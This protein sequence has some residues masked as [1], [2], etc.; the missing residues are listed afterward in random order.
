[1]SNANTNTYIPPP[2]TQGHNPYPPSPQHQ[3]PAAR[4]PNMP[5]YAPSGPQSELPSPTTNQINIS[6]PLDLK[7][8]GPQPILPPVR[9]AHPPPRPSLPSRSAS[10]RR[11]PSQNAQRQESSAGSVNHTLNSQEVTTASSVNG[12]NQ[13]Q[14]NQQSHQ[15]GN[16]ASDQYQP[17][18]PYSNQTSPQNSPSIRTQPNSP[19]NDNHPGTSPTS[20]YFDNKSSTQSDNASLLTVASSSGLQRSNSKINYSSPLLRHQSRSGPPSPSTPHQPLKRQTS[21]L[22]NGSKDAPYLSN[23]K[24]YHSHLETLNQTWEPPGPISVASSSASPPSS[25]SHHPLAKL[26]SASNLRAL[27]TAAATVT[28][29]G[30]EGPTVTSVPLSPMK[31]QE[32]SAA[33]IASPGDGSGLQGAIASTDGAQHA[34]EPKD[35]TVHVPTYDSDN[36]KVPVPPSPVVSPRMGPTQSNTQNT[37]NFLNSDPTLQRSTSR[38]RAPPIQVQ[39]GQSPQSALSPQSM[40]SPISPGRRHPYHRWENVVPSHHTDGSGKDRAHGQGQDHQDD[41]DYED[42][43]VNDDTDGD[44]LSGPEDHT[45]RRHHRRQKPEGTPFTPTRSAPQPPHLNGAVIPNSREAEIAHIMYIQ[46]QQALFLQEKAMNPPLRNKISNGNLSGGNS[47]GT[48]PHRKG[49]RRK[50]ITVISEPKLVSTTNQIKT[51]PI[52]RPVDQ[53]D[54]EDAGAKSEYT[55]GGEGI[56]K[57]VQ[58]MRKAVRHAANGVFHDDDSDREDAHG[59]KSDAEKK[60]GLKQ[61]KALKSKLAKRLNRPGHGGDSRR[62]QNGELNEQGGEEGSRGPVQFFSEDNLRARY[63]AQEQQGGNSFAAMGASLRRSNTTRDNASGGASL[64]KRHDQADGDKQEYEAE[65]E[66]KDG[67]EADAA[68]TQQGAD[69][70]AAKKAKLA[71]FASRTFDK[72]EMIEVNDGSGESFFVPRWDMDPRA[73]ELKSSKSVISVHSTRK[74]ERSTSSSTTTSVKTTKP[75]AS[76]AERLQSSA[77]A[78]ETTD[79]T[80][81]AEST[82]TEKPIKA[83]NGAVSEMTPAEAAMLNITVAPLA[84]SDASSAETVTAT[85]TTKEKDPIKADEG[86]QSGLKNLDEPLPTTAETASQETP[87]SPTAEDATEIQDVSTTSSSGLA[88]RTSVQS[89]TSSNVSSVGGIVYAQVLTRQSSM[90]RNFKRTEKDDLNEKSE[91]EV[92]TSATNTSEE[93][94]TSPT[95]SQK[96]SHFGLGIS[97]PLAETEVNQKDISEQTVAAPLNTEKEL[98]PLPTNEQAELA[99]PESGASALMTVRPLSPI[100]RC[101]SDL[102]RSP[103]PASVASGLSTRSSA[104]NDQVDASLDTATQSSQQSSDLG[105]KKTNGLRSMSSSSL[106]LPAAPTSPLPSPSMS[107]NTPSV[108]P[109]MPFPAVLARQG[110]YLT[111]RGSVRSMYADSIYDCYDYDSASELDSQAGLELHPGSRQGSFSSPRIPTLV[112]EQNEAPVIRLRKPDAAYNGT[113]LKEEEQHIHYE[114]IPKAV[115]YRMSMMTT[116][117]VEPVGVAASLSIPSRPP[118]HPMRQS[119]QG[120]IGT[121][122]VGSSDLTYSD[123]WASNSFRNTRDDLS[124]WGDNESLYSRRPSFA[125]TMSQSRVSHLSLRSERTMSVLMDKSHPRILDDADVSSLKRRGSEASATSVRF[126]R[127]PQDEVSRRQWFSE[128]NCG[129]WGSIQT[130]SSD[131][132]SSSASSRSSQFYF[133]GH[134]PTPSPTEER[135]PISSA[136]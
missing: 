116:V 92:Q 108:G 73:D 128:R 84:S 119:R 76:I 36:Y 66:G 104:V 96:S 39:A 15:Q 111:E 78:E 20:S 85:T 86:V 83:S 95:P 8:S 113:D 60:G 134:S 14:N 61:L 67:Q 103:F 99:I 43:G 82:G 70:E 32:L 2:P 55:S 64:L 106:T 129:T 132:V 30:T 63:L 42:E 47:D 5:T 91:T 94:E 38:R 25:G 57:K 48:K 131:S 10:L 49:S 54:N 37:F 18:S 101:A 53:S 26:G 77:E 6:G 74:L 97:L 33:G 123:S 75:A 31:S 118:R 19:G 133:N 71:K 114:D 130:S 40:T 23:V 50:K 59:S 24:S 120:S 44:V 51:V 13:N 100:R 79:I 126:P 81:T 62:D 121:L 21:I 17:P 41:G 136:F 29:S 107:S 46:Q 52:V 112:S 34:Q 110:S 80:E 93:A 12:E 3:G 69:E 68:S 11:A 125:S 16:L 58:K 7:T 122:S 35:K 28:A 56:K 105:D 45:D 88:S 117:P 27:A 1:M 22:K 87:Q 127:E 65:E 98:P 115:P 135:A 90:R 89:E 72:D 124:G 4:S 9:D 109:M 102:E